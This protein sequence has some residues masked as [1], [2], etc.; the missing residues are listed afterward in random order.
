MFFHFHY[1]EHS[2]TS[3]CKSLL[4]DASVLSFWH[5]CHNSKPCHI[6]L[7]IFLSNQAPGSETVKNS[8]RCHQLLEKLRSSCYAW[9][10]W[11]ITSGIQC[12]ASLPDGLLW[13][14]NKQMRDDLKCALIDLTGCLKTLQPS[15]TNTGLM[16]GFGLFTQ[17][18]LRY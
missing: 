17:F 3:Q 9:L 15:V 1:S 7:F 5:L 13:K 8:H 16:Y 6:N 4:A 18:N 11:S 14:L 10:K 12:P 2:L